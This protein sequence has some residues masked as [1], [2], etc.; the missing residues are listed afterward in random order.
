MTARML[1]HGIR[2]IS[3]MSNPQLQPKLIKAGA[4]AVVCPNAIGALRMAS[5]MI[6]PTAVDFLDHMLRSDKGNLR[7][8]ELTVSQK[9]KFNQKKIRECGLEERYG[10]LVLGARDRANDIEFN[11]PPTRQLIVGTTLIV[12]GAVEEI[13]RAQD[14]F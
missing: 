2:I 10:L 13:A 5:E 7:I 6:R 11:P 4:D 9:S 12:M 14:A 1:N 3:R 8:H